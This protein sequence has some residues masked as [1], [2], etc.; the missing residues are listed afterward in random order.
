MLLLTDKPDVVTALMNAA[1]HVVAVKLDEARDGKLPKL[2]VFC[3]AM[4]IEAG[5]AWL[6]L[7][8]PVVVKQP[9]RHITSITSAGGSVR[10]ATPPPAALDPSLN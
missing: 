4:A 3:A 6:R 10:D 1:R 2:Q 9:W 8:A 7:C 5:Y